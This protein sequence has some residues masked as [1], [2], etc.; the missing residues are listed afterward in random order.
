MILWVVTL[1]VGSPVG[2]GDKEGPSRVVT[3]R[4]FALS[5]SPLVSL[6]QSPQISANR[7]PLL[8]TCGRFPSFPPLYYLA[9]FSFSPSC[10]MS[11][12]FI[13]LPLY[14]LSPAFHCS[15]LVRPLCV[16]LLDAN[17]CHVLCRQ[18]RTSPARCPFISSSLPPLPPS[19][20][21]LPL[22]SSLPR[23]GFC[24]CPL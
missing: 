10:Q 22:P 15:V 16:S 12:L 18:A 19:S 9:S 21:G 14:P 5:A 7:N 17:C 1:E 23:H 13:S 8:C 6:N 4:F 11:P 20:T 2:P 24:P 3:P